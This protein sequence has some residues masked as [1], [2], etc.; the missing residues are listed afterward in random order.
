MNIGISESTDKTAN[1]NEMIY[2]LKRNECHR[3]ESVKESRARSV[4]RLD[5]SCSVVGCLFLKVGIYVSVY[6]SGFLI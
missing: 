3:Y 4:S 2:S 1:I 6:I 5:I